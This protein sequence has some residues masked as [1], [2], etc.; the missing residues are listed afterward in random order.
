[1]CLRCLLRSQTK[2]EL[3][4]EPKASPQPWPREESKV[5][6]G[7]PEVSS[8]RVPARQPWGAEA[9]QLRRV[10]YSDRS[11][12]TDLPS[13]ALFLALTIYILTQKYQYVYEFHLCTML[14]QVK[15]PCGWIRLNFYP[16]KSHHFLEVI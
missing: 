14:I 13:W 16:Q 9:G 6:P 7:T 12:D 1:M 2:S 10:V 5:H 4:F 3:W 11:P 15:S 8:W